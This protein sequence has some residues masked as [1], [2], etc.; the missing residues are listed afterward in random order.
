MTKPETERYI[1][2]L[3]VV[4]VLVVGVAV[5]APMWLPA[6][7]AKAVGE[8]SAKLCQFIIVPLALTSKPRKKIRKR[9]R[10]VKRV[11]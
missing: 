6:A 2:I 4:G 8:I 1:S 9:R 3:A 11:N 7:K 10:K 5:T